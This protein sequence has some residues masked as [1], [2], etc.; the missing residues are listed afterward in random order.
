MKFSKAGL[1]TILF[2]L[3]MLFGAL[4]AQAAPV[5]AGGSGAEFTKPSIDG[6]MW[7]LEEHQEEESGE[8]STDGE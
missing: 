7:A 1:S 6:V 5:K 3:S 8:E 2:A 4:G